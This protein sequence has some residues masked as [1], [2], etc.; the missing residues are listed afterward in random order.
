MTKKI[1]TPPSERTLKT[2]SEKATGQRLD[3]F[4]DRIDLRDWFY[5]PALISLPDTLVSCR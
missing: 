1:S 5:Q 3:A 4:P 2:S